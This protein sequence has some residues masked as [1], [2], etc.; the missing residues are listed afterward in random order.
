MNYFKT[1]RLQLLVN[2]DDKITD[3]FIA[4]VVFYH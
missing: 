1:E 4:S 3:D 2:D